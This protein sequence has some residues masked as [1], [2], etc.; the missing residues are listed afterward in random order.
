M[1]ILQQPRP[2]AL[3]LEKCVE[4]GVP[5]GPLLGQLKN[6]I[7]ITLPNGK[8]IFANDVKAPDD[9]GPIFIIID[10]PST[11]FI[12]SLNDLKNVFAKYQGTAE[13]ESA[14]LVVHFTPQSVMETS[15]Y[16]QFMGRFSKY[17]KHLILNASNK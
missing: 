5:P 2:G 11:E 9:P 4:N 7:D 10:I 16:Q 1:R 15:V 6:G 14:C 13:E 17:T 3:C 8:K 12:P